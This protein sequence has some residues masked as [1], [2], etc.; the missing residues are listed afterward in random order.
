MRS[1]S[2]SSPVCESIA[3]FFLKKNFANHWK[4]TLNIQNNWKY[5]KRKITNLT[6]TDFISFSSNLIGSAERCSIHMLHDY[7]LVT[8]HWLVLQLPE[9]ENKHFLLRKD[10]SI[11]L[12]INISI[13]TISINWMYFHIT[14]KI[15]SIESTLD[16]FKN[17]F[18]LYSRSFSFAYYRKTIAKT[19]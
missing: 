18:Y 8:I 16:I 15:S 1:F 4:I 3:I 5:L 2:F 10:L 6:I 7:I 13:G 14:I 17:H 19:S 9:I 11:Y 12:K